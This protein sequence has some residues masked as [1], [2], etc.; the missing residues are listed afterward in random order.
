MSM[1]QVTKMSLAYGPIAG[2]LSFLVVVALG[3]AARFSLLVSLVLFTT[4][5]FFLGYRFTFAVCWNRRARRLSLSGTL[6]RRC[7]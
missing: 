7:S 5:I 2:F 6:K 3:S 4:V 1:L